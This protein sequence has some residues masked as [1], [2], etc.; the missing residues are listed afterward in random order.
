MNMVPRDLEELQR[1]AEELTPDQQ[2]Q[3]AAFL[4]QRARGRTYT[5]KVVDLNKH[6]GTVQYPEEDAVAYQRR[7]RTEWDR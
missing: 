6:A 4:I 5:A 7:V 3:L 1:D 2:L